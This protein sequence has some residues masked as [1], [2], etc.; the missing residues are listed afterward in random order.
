MSKLKDQTNCN[1]MKCQGRA[2]FFMKYTG[3]DDS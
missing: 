3:N 2:G 1:S